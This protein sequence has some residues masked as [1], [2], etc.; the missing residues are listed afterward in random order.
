VHVLE[1]VVGSVLLLTTIVF[2][3]Q[4]TAI[5]PLSVSTSDRHIETQ[6][7]R[8]AD[9][10]LDTAAVSTDETHPQTRL[11]HTLLYWNTSTRTFHNANATGYVGEQ[12]PTPFGEV[13][14]AVF[15]DKTIATNIALTYT[16]ATGPDSTTQLVSMGEPS[17]NAVSA[18]EYVVLYDN[19]SLTAPD[20][21]RTVGNATSYAVPDAFP[22]SPVYNVIQVRVSVWQI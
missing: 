10:V 11:K 14:D 16:R 18:T 22:E 9:G 3:I 20:E 12:P 1:A 17:N 13:L 4:S 15:T 19:E 6:Q 5:T 2:V 7:Q 21:T 8:V